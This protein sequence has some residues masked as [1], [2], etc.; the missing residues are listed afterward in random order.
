MQSILT[1]EFP[2]QIITK[3]GNGFLIFTFQ[4]NLIAFLCAIE[5]GM[6]VPFFFF[7]ST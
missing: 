1:A 3:K 5:S 4:F 7:N 2:W 6:Q